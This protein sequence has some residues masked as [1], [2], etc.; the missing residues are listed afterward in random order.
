MKSKQVIRSEDTED[1]GFLKQK[2]T[3]TWKCQSAVLRRQRL[4]RENSAF[5]HPW[6][7]FNWLV[8]S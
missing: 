3:N 7:L 8:G 4:R 6:S 5:R 1:A 2:K